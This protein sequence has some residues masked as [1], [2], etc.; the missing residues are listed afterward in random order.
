M[1]Y[2]LRV[3]LVS[4]FKKSRCVLKEEF[5]RSLKL[6]ELMKANI[7]SKRP[8]IGVLKVPLAS[9]DDFELVCIFGSGDLWLFWHFYSKDRNLKLR[10]FEVLELMVDSLF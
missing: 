6:L 7:L 10:T 8:W 5:F 1:F 2:D 3:W 9:Y 4:I